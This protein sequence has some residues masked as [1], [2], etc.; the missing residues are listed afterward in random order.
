MQRLAICFGC[1]G[2]IAGI[3]S[4]DNDNA[5]EWSNWVRGNF[6]LAIFRLTSTYEK[7]SSSL[8]YRLSMLLKCTES[9]IGHKAYPSFQQDQLPVSLHWR[10]AFIPISIL[11]SVILSSCGY[12]LSLYLSP[13]SLSLLQDECPRRDGFSTVSSSCPASCSRQRHSRRT[14]L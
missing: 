2:G 5:P 3:F 6:L 7:I 12:V 13:P 8:L 11:V 10:N 14:V 1:R 9:H 4:D